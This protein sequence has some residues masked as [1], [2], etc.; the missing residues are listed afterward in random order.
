[1]LI[2]DKGSSVVNEDASLSQSVDNDVVVVL[3]HEQNST[4]ESGYCSHVA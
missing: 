2:N 3:H 1:M 4:R